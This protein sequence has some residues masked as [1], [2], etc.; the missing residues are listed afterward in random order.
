M[1]INDL[2]SELSIKSK[3]IFKKILKKPNVN[4]SF[5]IPDDKD[6]TELSVV[7]FSTHTFILFKEEFSK[8]IKTINPKYFSFFSSKLI[9]KL[10][11]L[12]YKDKINFLNKK[13]FF[14]YKL[15]RPFLGKIF[16][17]KIETDEFYKLNYNSVIITLTKNEYDRL[18]YY[19]SYVYKL[20]QLLNLNKE[21]NI[22][23]EFSIIF[24]D[25]KKINDLYKNINENFGN[26]FGDDNTDDLNDFFEDDDD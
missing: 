1:N 17:D 22:Y 13:R 5:Q 23:Q 11:E 7:K 24:D 12:S 9:K 18:L 3:E 4:I 2:D 20:K 6:V 16:L 8:K 10:N 19:T 25:D 14:Y 15:L 21:L 26:F